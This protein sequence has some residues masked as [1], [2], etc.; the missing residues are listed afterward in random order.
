MSGILYT[1]ETKLKELTVGQL[2]D[3]IVETLS[4]GTF[5]RFEPEKRYYQYD[6]GYTV[7]PNTVPYPQYPYRPNE[8]PF[9]ESN[10]KGAKC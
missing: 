7:K 2:K 6:H 10:D 5:T 3:I 9:C 8:G 4:H 1:N